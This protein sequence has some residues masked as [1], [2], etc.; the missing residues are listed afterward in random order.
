LNKKLDSREDCKVELQLL[1]AIVRYPDLLKIA[2]SNLEKEDFSTGFCLDFFS[3]VTDM[4][5]KDFGVDSATITYWD[6]SNLY[7]AKMREIGD[8]ISSLP[9]ISE[10]SFEEYILIVKEQS[11]VRKIAKMRDELSSSIVLT[12]EGFKEE[13]AAFQGEVEEMLWKSS[14]RDIFLSALEVLETTQKNVHPNLEEKLSFKDNLRKL[15]KTFSDKTSA[16]SLIQTGFPDLDTLI[17]GFSP[18]NLCILAGRPGM[19]KTALCLS[20]IKNISF[21]E[22]LPVGMISL[23]MSQHELF[24]RLVSS[25]SNISAQKIRSG[26]LSERELKKIEKDYEIIKESNLYT[27]DV[28]R[29]TISNL[30]TSAERLK[31]KYDIKFLFIDY[32]QLISGSRESRL[33]GKYEEITE[34]SRELKCLAGE[35]S[36]PILCCSQLSRSVESRHNKRPLIS[37]LRDSGAIEQDADVILLI[38]RDSYY[39]SSDHSEITEVS[40]S[41]NRNGMTGVSRLKFNS[42]IVTFESLPDSSF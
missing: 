4:H 21:T 5:K 40:V 26:N 28:N 23:E 19:G 14:K 18:G 37:D 1:C 41:K 6:K 8:S 36:L 38:Y 24:Q 42:K 31:S 25:V 30:R 3:H 29:L 27:C 15:V 12:P 39:N 20:I 22:K 35:L 7:K 10:K 32:L 17:G 2:V 16:P 33:E 11:E 34:I 13:L 9:S